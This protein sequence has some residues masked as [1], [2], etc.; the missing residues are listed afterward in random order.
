MQLIEIS[1]QQNGGMENVHGCFKCIFSN[2]LTK[3]KNELVVGCVNVYG[4]I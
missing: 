2:F 4:H 3:M 1:R